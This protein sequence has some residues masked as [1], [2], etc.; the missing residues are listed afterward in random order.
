MEFEVALTLRENGVDLMP[1]AK[2][3]AQIESSPSVQTMGLSLAQVKLI[4]TC[5][6]TEIVEQQITRLSNRLRPCVHCGQ[7]RKLKD[8]HEIH[9]CSLFG[10]VVMRVPRWRMCNCGQGR[11]QANTGRRQRWI[12]AELEFVQSQLAAT[13]PYAKA[14][15]LL[16]MLLPTTNAGSVSTVRRHALTTGK[17]LDQQG[18]IA[19]QAPS[20]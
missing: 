13:I 16:N 2:W 14:A 3:A 18:L 19:D 6:Q 15:E 12:S 17:Y 1:A 10:E 9:Y 8:F 7:A 5:L 11:D 20:K 4:L